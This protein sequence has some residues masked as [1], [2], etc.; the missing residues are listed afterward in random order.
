[1]RTDLS[2]ECP[3]G[4]SIQLEFNTSKN[5]YFSYSFLFILLTIQNLPNKQFGYRQTGQR[6]KTVLTFP[7][8]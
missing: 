8:C 3:S 4:N 2:S 7:K 1:M 5:N 6:V